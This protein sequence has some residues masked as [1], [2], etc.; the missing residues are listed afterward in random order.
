MTLP[1]IRSWNLGVR[2]GA[3]RPMPAPRPPRRGSARSGVERRRHLPVRGIARI[4]GVSGSTLY[5]YLTPDGE[6][7]SGTPTLAG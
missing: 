3:M 6:R 7:R 2:A 1:A 5:R 4:V